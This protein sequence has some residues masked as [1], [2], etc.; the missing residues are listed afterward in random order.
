MSNRYRILPRL[1]P[2]FLPHLPLGLVIG[3]GGLV[4]GLSE[5]PA[6][7]PMDSIAIGT[8]RLAGPALT[9]R[10]VSDDTVTVADG[11]S[12]AASAALLRARTGETPGS[13]IRPDDS[14]ALVGLGQAGAAPTMAFLDP[15]VVGITRQPETDVEPDGVIRKPATDRFL[16]GDY[17]LNPARP[18]VGTGT[19]I[20][21]IDLAAELAP[22][23]IIDQPARWRNI[24]QWLSRYYRADSDDVARYV[25]FAF[26]SGH[27]NGVDPLLITAVMSIESSLNPKARSQ[28]DARGLMQVL[29]R[30][31]REKFEHLGGVKAAYDPRVSIE[32]GTRILRRMIDRTGSVEKALKQYVGAANLRSDGGY[33]AKVIAQRDR[34]W[35]AAYGLRIPSE[36]D[37]IV[38][39]TRANLAQAGVAS[40]LAD[41]ATP[42]DGR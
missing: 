32:V 12:G 17:K 27:R 24:A 37:L 41:A 31:H 22:V 26:D 5:E 28:K 30:A 33:G 6:A 9:S 42:A 23:H 7:R 20:D 40:Y 34:I 18:F 14:H 13:V 38:A 10:S 15:S 11:L 29:V 4:M 39:T 36:P 1:L 19:A 16:P 35:A 8:I 3:A 25:R 2:R 21:T